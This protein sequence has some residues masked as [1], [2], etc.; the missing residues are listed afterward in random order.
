MKRILLL[1]GKKGAGVLAALLF[2][3]P[4]AGHAGNITVSN[5]GQ[6]AAAVH[7][8]NAAGT[9]TTI[10]M[11]AGT[12]ALPDTALVFGDNN[13][14]SLTITTQGGAVIIQGPATDKILIVNTVSWTNVNVSVTGVTFENGNANDILGGGAI[15]CGGPANSATFTNCIFQNNTVSPNAGNA[16]GGAVHMTGGGNFTFTNCT[17]TSNS[18]A[19]GNGGALGYFTQGVAGSLTVT[20]C[21]F[22]GNSV[23]SF[24]SL[25]TPV[26][27]AISISATGTGLSSPISITQNTFVS[28]TDAQGNGG[29][30]DIEY[31]GSTNAVIKYNRF[32]KNTAGA[33]PDV[34]MAP[35]TS[36]GN[37]DITDNWWGRNVSPVGA[38]DP[39]A[40]MTGSGS[41]SLISNSFIELTSTGSAASICDGTGGNS[42]VVTAGF[43]KNSAGTTISSANLGAFTGVPI[44]YSTSQGTFTGAQAAIQSN[45]TATVTFIDNGVA[46]TDN[47]HPVVD[48]VTTSDVPADAAITV[49]AP[50][51]LAGTGTSGTSSAV[52]STPIITD[53]SCNQICLVTPSGASPVSGSVTGMV[54]IDAS[55]QMDH[56]VPYL[57]RHYDITPA[58]NAA[59]ATATITLYFLQTEFNMYNASV[60]DPS[61]KLPTGP[62]DMTGRGNLSIT[63]F[64]GTGTVPGSYTGWTGSGPATVLITP[65]ASNVVWNSAKNWWEVSFSVTGFSGFYVTGAIGVPLPVDLED[66]GGVASGSG[67]LLS[68]KVGIETGLSR[69]EVQRSTDGVGFATIGS[70][71]PG[72]RQF[73]DGSAVVGSD[74]YRLRMVNVDGSFTYSKVVVVD[75]SGSASSGAAAGWVRVLGNPFSGA[76]SVAIVG[77]AGGSG[78]SGASGAGLGIVS[79]RLASAS[80]VVIWR[81]EVA[82]G[83]GGTVVQLD[84]TSR[85]ASG[86]YFLTVMGAQG[87]E[88]VKLVKQ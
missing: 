31:V 46:G 48:S 45:G 68:W 54:T 5:V 2:L 78:G 33:F 9:T 53:G 40:G 73:Y 14:E 34:A 49:V 88:T 86:V 62:T 52:A 8:A 37:V 26:G 65:G 79:L 82:V 25:F 59:T 3:L 28:N 71:Q 63:Q 75:V 66:F 84:A 35:I 13:N 77:P 47:V 12:Y 21:T 7:N 4:M 1:F 42:T 81:S 64:H 43:T 50:S 10:T 11:M 39:H 74:F 70:V 18:T 67:V 44:S 20:G 55:T 83:V 85:L 80:G 22:T 56:G 23:A 32:Y 58:A 51:S 24:E 61:L 36:G 17:F 30:I 38:T 16:D 27:G 19:D 41:G 57:T 76:C 60:S 29:A 69:Y 15:Q 87:Q 72:G 6:L